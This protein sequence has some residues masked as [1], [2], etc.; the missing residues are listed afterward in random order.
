[1]ALKK[2][3]ELQLLLSIETVLSVFDYLIQQAS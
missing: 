1:M 3:T 2:V